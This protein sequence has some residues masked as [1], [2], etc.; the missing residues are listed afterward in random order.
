MLL[1]CVRCDCCERTKAKKRYPLQSQTSELRAVYF[2]CRSHTDQVGG[3]KNES[4]VIA[5]HLAVA[6][7]VICLALFSY[8]LFSFCSFVIAA[9]AAAAATAIPRLYITT[10]SVAADSMHA[11]PRVAP[12]SV[13]GIKNVAGFQF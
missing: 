1:C 4:V 6:A 3:P 2:H 13:P 10:L 8:S 11:C 9:A 5:E 12:S 7:F